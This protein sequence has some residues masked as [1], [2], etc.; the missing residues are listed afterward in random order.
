MKILITGCSWVQRMHKQKY[1]KD[2]DIDLKSFGGQGLWRIEE[3][4][5][6]FDV[7]VYDYVFIQLPTPIRN[8]A[9]SKSTTSKFNKF[10]NDIKKIGEKP[11]VDKWLN[12]YKQKIIDVNKLHKNIVFFLY[13][14]GG[15]PLRHPYDYG[16][17]IDNEMIE[18]L[19][20]SDL[21]HIYLSF[22]GMA[23]YGMDEEKCDDSEFWEYY[24][25]N[26]P[27]NQSNKDFKKYWSIISPKG[28][29]SLDPHPNEKANKDAIDMIC[30]YIRGDKDDKEN[31]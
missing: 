26:N 4:L 5:K 8:D 27:A 29:I 28:W 17:N 9:E 6:I 22:E 21:N 20:Q 1:P 30:N 31:S 11:A 2:I 14:V 16:V 12:N 24:H 10:I 15:Y 3:H 19:K 25:I 13:N 23:G 18:F 7:R